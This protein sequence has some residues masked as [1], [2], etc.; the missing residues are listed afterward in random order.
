MVFFPA[1]KEKG[2][3]DVT[4]TASSS[5]Q[6]HGVRTYKV[7]DHVQTGM[8][9]SVHSPADAFAVALPGDC[10][11]LAAR[12][13]DIVLSLSKQSLQLSQRSSHLG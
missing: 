12:V 4:R 11:M 13:A 8:R 1:C 10:E 7:G 9:L 2:C 6:V 5:A 3:G